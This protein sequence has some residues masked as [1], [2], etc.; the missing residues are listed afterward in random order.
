MDF[1]GFGGLTAGV[2]G[3]GRGF[4]K[5]GTA[6]GAMND[7]CGINGVAF[8]DTNCW[9]AGL[10]GEVRDS[11]SGGVAI[12]LNGEIASLKEGT[13]GIGVNAMNWAGNAKAESAFNGLGEFHHG[14]NLE[15]VQGMSKLF[16][17]AGN[18]PVWIYD[19]TPPKP[20]GKLA[21]TI[22]GQTFYIP[23]CN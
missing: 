4:G 20:L 13:R 9:A 18:N 21:I 22:D 16:M 1:N 3:V 2:T 8:K 11:V 19:P 17:L 15:G 5:I 10:H 23:V 7:V 12:G 14:I 6:T